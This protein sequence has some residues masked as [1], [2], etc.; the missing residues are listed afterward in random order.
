M[1]TNNHFTVIKRAPS[2][3]TTQSLS[4]PMSSN[5]LRWWISR[6]QLTPSVLLAVSPTNPCDSWAWCNAAQI[7]LNYFNT[8]KSCCAPADFPRTASCPGWDEEPRIQFNFSKARQFEAN[9][10]IFQTWWWVFWWWCWIAWE[11]LGYCYNW[12][13]RI[14]FIVHKFSW[15]IVLLWLHRCSYSRAVRL[16]PRLS[17]PVTSHMLLLSSLSDSLC[18]PRPRLSHQWCLTI[19]LSGLPFP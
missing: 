2:G 1:Y 19:L 6:Y 9:L 4:L 16:L 17:R 11:G 12:V 13:V 18:R 10:Q 14:R 3:T 8:D 7:P 15:G 5:G